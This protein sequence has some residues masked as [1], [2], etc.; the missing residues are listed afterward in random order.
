M[1]TKLCLPVVASVLM[2]FFQKT[3]IFL[4]EVENVA[5]CAARVVGEPSGVP[6][7]RPVVEQPVLSAD[8]GGMDPFTSGDG[9]EYGFNPPCVHL[10]CI[11]IRLVETG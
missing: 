10:G 6:P 1:T 2:Y 7:G 3:V 9:L 5:G 11:Y 8:P 4:K